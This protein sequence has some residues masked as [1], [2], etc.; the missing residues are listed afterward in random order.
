LTIYKLENHFWIFK[1]DQDDKNTFRYELKSKTTN[2]TY[3]DE[4]YHYR[5]L[6]SNKKRSRYDYLFRA[7]AEQRAKNLVSRKIHTDGKENLVIEGQ[8]EG[9]EIYLTQKFTL[10]NESKWLD[11]YI[12]ISNRGKRRV[13]LGHINLGFK[14]ALFKQ[15]SSWNDHLDEYALTSI[16][17]R[18]F[19]CYGDDR[20]KELYTPNDLVFGA[21]IDVTTE[22]PGYCDE[23]WLWGNSKGGLLTCN[24]NS[25]Q[26]E[27]SRFQRSANKLPGR[28]AEDV[29]IV[30]GGVYLYEGNPEA[31]TTLKSQES[32]S[33]GVSRYAVM[34]FMKVIIKMDTIFIEVI[35]RNMYINIVMI[36]THQ[37]IG[38]NFIILDGPMKK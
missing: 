11:E 2:E 29:Y 23:G 19:Y 21:W 13:R 15:Y 8:F 4:D 24:Y 1:I 17:A 28:G 12:T 9:T 7:N 36:M 22:M 6:K 5:L 14:K 25:T 34:R 33:F 26:M 37:F 38:M 10:K 31:V 35:L 32:Y 27:Y 20:K 3:A 30:F 16:P 18:R